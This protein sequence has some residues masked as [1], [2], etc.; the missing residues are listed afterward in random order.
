MILEIIKIIVFIVIA[1]ILYTIS[2]EIQKLSTVLSTKENINEANFV[3]E[4]IEEK[5]IISKKIEI[6]N[7]KVSYM[8]N[9]FDEDEFENNTFGIKRE[10]IKIKPL[11]KII[12]F[13]EEN[14]FNR[15]TFDVDEKSQDV[16]EI[17]T[18]K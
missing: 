8:E 5:E 10:D 14:V 7:L 4:D 1:Y 18:I 17:K 3:K 16:I 9:E 2:I 6:P 11:E 15:F 13:S 12:D